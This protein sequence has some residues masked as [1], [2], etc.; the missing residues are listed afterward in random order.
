LTPEHTDKIADLK[1]Y[2]EQNDVGLFCIIRYNKSIFD[3]IF[4]RRLPNQL[5]NQLDV[6]VLVIKE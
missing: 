6:P 3:K 1:N 5:T 4:G 2:M